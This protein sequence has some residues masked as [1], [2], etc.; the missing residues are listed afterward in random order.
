MALRNTYA[1]IDPYAVRVVRLTTHALVKRGGIPAADRQD[2][3]Q[4]LMLDLLRRLPRFDA[5][6]AS[7]R[8]FTARVVA[9]CATRIVAAAWEARRM[10]RRTESLHEEVEDGQGGRVEQWETLDT[11]CDRRRPG[12]QSADGESLDLRLDV[13]ALLSDLPREM[14]E[15]CE[16]LRRHSVA[17]LGRA[18]ETARGRLWRRVPSVRARFVAAGIDAYLPT[19]RFSEP[20]SK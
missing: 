14:R 7:L 8:T 20:V 9:H 18:T 3:E 17:G 10:A 1:G 12:R 4:E 16:G 6:R 5:S 11:D 19:G 2:V 13:D 15:L